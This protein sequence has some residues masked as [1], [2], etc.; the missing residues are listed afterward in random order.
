MTSHSLPSLANSKCRHVKGEFPIYPFSASSQLC[1]EQHE[2]WSS[3]AFGKQ[4]L[5]LLKKNK[6]QINKLS[7]EVDEL[8]DNIFYFIKN[9][10]DSSV[11]ASNFYIHILGYLQDMIQSL[12][13]ITKVSHKH[14]HNNHKKLKFNQL[15]LTCFQKNL[16]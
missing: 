12:E 1:R 4:D 5:T 7:D 16:P 11:G 6:K 8:R 10:D 13:Y 14:V 2:V 15:V 3:N 9:L